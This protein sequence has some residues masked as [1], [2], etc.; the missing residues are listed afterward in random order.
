[1]AR[2]LVHENRCQIKDELD[3]GFL[4]AL[5]Q[6]LSFKVQGA[7]HTKAYKLHVWDGR[8][9]LLADNL[10]FPIGLRQRVTEFYKKHD[11]QVDIEDLREANSTGKP[12]DI[13]TT[14]Q[15]VNKIPY[16]YQLESVA[17]LKNMIAEL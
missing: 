7:E 2:I 8:R 4:W 14:L 13:L 3:I 16:P 1:M 12:I 11:K 9:K 15:K 10:N 17:L 6:E 5:D